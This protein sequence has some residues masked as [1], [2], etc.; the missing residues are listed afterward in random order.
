MPLAQQIIDSLDKA[1]HGDAWYG[2]STESLLTG[3][4]AVDAARRPLGSAHS[5]WELV[6]H[7][8][9]WQ[10]EVGRRLGGSAPAWPD[11]GDWQDIDSPNEEDWVSVKTALADSTRRLIA[12]LATPWIDYAALVG[13]VRS[14]ELG[15][16]VTVAETVLGVL[17]HNA[18][19]TGQIALL[20][21]AIESE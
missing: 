2:P 3:L 14:P 17:Q 7:L 4:T 8:I 21:R 13:T 1:H 5:I 10:N 18:Y 12:Q 20:R 6:L 19:H 11:E 16:G 9:A 15:T